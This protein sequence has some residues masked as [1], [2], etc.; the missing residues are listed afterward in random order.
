MLE[1]LFVAGALALA[2]LPTDS[3]GTGARHVTAYRVSPSVGAPAV[4]GRLDDAVWMATDSIGG[5]TQR[6][7]REGEPSRFR[8]VMRVAFDNDAIYVAARAY[9]PEPSKIAAQLSRRDE[10]SPS[11]W[12]YVGFDSRH[13]RRT[14]YIFG[15]NP[16]GVKRDLTTSDGGGDDEGW[17]AVWSVAVTRDSLGWTAEYRIPLSALRFATGGDG[18]WGFQALRVVQRE[19][20]QSYWAPV[21]R[22]EPRQVARFGELHGMNNLPAPR[23]LE[24]LPYTVSG[25]ARAPG[26]KADPFYSSSELRG[27]A[28]LDV[29]Y[30]V[31]SNLTLDATF[32]PDFGQVDADPSE[33]N[34]SAFETFLSERRPFFTEGADIFRFGIGLGDGDG[35]NESLFYSRRV[36][37]S[38][39]GDVDVPEGGFADEPGQTNILGAAKLSGQVGRGWSVGVMNAL[40]AQEQATIVDAAGVRSQ[41][42]V[43]PMTNYTVLRAIREL[44]GG[45]T[46]FGAVTTGVVRRL[47]G[48]GMDWLRSRALAGGF[49]ARHRW[50]N[51]H[52]SARVWVL[53]S[54]VQGSTEAILNAQEA[55]ARYFQRPGQS[56]LRVDSAATSLSGWA[57]SYD[58]ARVKGKW[59]GGFLGSFRSPG[60]ET[61]DLGFQRAADE[62]VN[63]F[64]MQH[65]QR[66]PGKVFRDWNLG[67]NAW[68]AR[69][70]GWERNGRAL[71]VNG[72]GR[73]LN[74]WNVW[75]GVE[76][77]FGGWDT[78]ALR[79]GAAILEPGGTS[80]WMGTSSDG[81]KRL[82]GD[83]SFN[84]GVRDEDSGWRYS[85]SAGLGWRPTPSL[86]FSASP[87]YSRYNTAW[88]YVTD[89]TVGDAQRYVF[90]ELD[91]RTFGMS[92]R[93]NKTF[94]PT[95]SL[96][97]YAQPFM[98]SG[99]YTGFR[100]PTAPGAGRFADRFTRL[101]AVR[102]ED[103]DYRA[104]ELAFEDPNFSVRDFNLNAV[105]RWEYRL[106][107]TF[108]VAWSHSRGGSDDITDGRFRFR[109]NFDALLDTEA[110]NVVMLKANWWVS[111]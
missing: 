36:G 95:L 30:G 54:S 40:T 42:V 1:S 53:G 58:V 49:D 85:V 80:G 46:Q 109:R 41:Q 27:S 83:A 90:A 91:Q 21:K 23:R 75:G 20:E 32:N 64:W 47:D 93:V 102:G 96:Q 43:E 9:D 66:T 77:S 89:E 39:R 92:A 16:A 13:D 104:G 98:S 65:I 2:A 94:T 38:P 67:G 100:E 106:G 63:V 37:R 8:T 79:G 10:D 107:S 88:Q 81:R 59:Q 103:G 78:R 11:D 25:V 82:T 101:A 60:F 68:E 55:S 24:L 70:F 18:V 4:D 48:T 62:I 74:Y 28:G 56:Y 5:F 50:G 84:W 72:S 17:D 51:D 3:A 86:R 87:F 52:Y 12:M 69:N 99:S 71:N 22:D 19:N 6:E 61:N 108:F 110:S 76:R 31:T 111:L 35:G 57:A 14:A 97:L 44:N 7:P 34:L 29:K 45:K 15:V 73:F 105:L 26:E 33:V